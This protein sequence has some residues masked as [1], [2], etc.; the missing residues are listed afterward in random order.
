MSE[1]VQQQV[2]KIEGISPDMLWTFL[3]VLVGLAALIVLGHKVIE[4]FRKEHE[5]KVAKQELSSQ[6]IEERI[7]DK[8]MEKLT[9]QITEKF[10]KFEQSFEKKFEEIDKKLDNDKENIEAHTRQLND[11]ENRVGRL[12]GDSKA[13]CHGMLALLDLVPDS[14]KAKHAMHNY[15][16]TGKYDKE[17]WE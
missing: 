16:L 4:I 15:L 17:D 10:N 7:A 5:R 12:E 2:Q 6:G 8:V 11:H 13:L 9:P 14:G 1:Q 3:V